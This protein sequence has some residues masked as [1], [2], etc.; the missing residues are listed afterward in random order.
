ML[1]LPRFFVKLLVLKGLASESPL[2]DRKGQ[3]PKVCLGDSPSHRYQPDLR[4]LTRSAG[5]PP[6]RHVAGGRLV[7]P[8]VSHSQFGAAHDRGRRPRRLLYTRIYRLSARKTT[9]GA[10]AIRATRLLGRC[11]DS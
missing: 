3:A 5:S 8:G 11:S 6:A 1:F 9:K 7:H 2:I 4:I 10:M